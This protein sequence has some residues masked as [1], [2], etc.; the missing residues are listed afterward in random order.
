MSTYRSAIAY[1]DIVLDRYH[2][3]DYA[4]DAL[5]GKAT[6]LRERH[7]Y[8]AAL[9]AVNLFFQKYP[10]SGLKKD[11]ETLKSNIEEDI[12]APKPVRK[13]SVGLSTNAGQ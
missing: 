4:D 2:D 13:K 3:S 6:A 7:D 10:S 8:T 9:D 5:L 11:A 1:F 12:A